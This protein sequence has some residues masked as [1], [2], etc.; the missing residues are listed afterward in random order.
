MN[1]KLNDLKAIYKEVKKRN[2]KFIIMTGGVLSGLGKGV[3]LAS[4]GSL[5]SEKILKIPIKCDGYLNYDPGTMNPLEHGEVFVL[6]DGSE[7]DM[8]FGHYERFLNINCN[9]SQNITM[10]KIYKDIIDLERKGAFL[11]NTVKLIPEVTNYIQV[12]IMNKAITQNAEVVLLE[13]GGTIGDIE[14]ELY[15]YAVKEMIYNLGSN[16]INLHLTFIPEIY[17]GEQKTKP[18]QNSLE[19]LFNRGIRPDVV[20]CRTKKQLDKSSVKKLSVFSG[21]S[22][23][24]IISAIDVTN[25]YEIPLIFA[26]QKLDEII[27][28]QLNISKNTNF[29]LFKERIQKITTNHKNSKV[30]TIGI[31]GKYT[32]I[33]DSYASV[34]E[35]INHASTFFDTKTNIVFIDTENVNKDQL[36]QIDGIIVPGGFGNRGVEGKIEVI[37]YARE[38]RIPFLGLC[39]GLQLAVIEYAK[40]VLNINCNSTEVDP[41]TPNPIITIL[42]NQNL[43]ILGGTMRLGSYESILLEKTKTYLAYNKKKVYERHR[44][45]YEVN[46]KY[47]QQLEDE[48]F[49]ISGK[50]PDDRLV[51]FIELKNH[52]FFVATQ[53]HPELKSRV[54]E[55]HPLFIS[56][57]KAVNN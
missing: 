26:N 25:I 22:E 50:S 41:K 5:I 40:N 24:K 27:C 11:G 53:S 9:G 29:F 3:A 23:N 20:I 10:G 56:F 14:N 51:E 49:I 55:P 46:P 35:A 17:G 31:C 28:N 1:Y 37:K 47:H 7:V 44:H 30:K 45:R 15:V 57:L 39:Y 18:A 42:S 16:I 13:I 34:I 12:C 8:D 36:K 21:L 33:N 4:V 54:L 6:D 43:K 52:P 19:K 38:N 48:N 32:K 2:I